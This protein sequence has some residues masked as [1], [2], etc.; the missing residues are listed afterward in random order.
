MAIS[1]TFQ[2]ELHALPKNQY[3]GPSEHQSWAPGPRLKRAALLK[4]VGVSVHLAVSLLD[5]AR[6]ALI[7][8]LLLREKGNTDDIYIRPKAPCIDD[9]YSNQS[10]GCWY[11][12]VRQRREDIHDNLRSDRRGLTFPTP[13][14]CQHWREA[15]HCANSLAEVVSVSDLAVFR[16]LRDSVGM[17]NFHLCWMTQELTPDLHYRRLEIHG[18][19]LLVLEAR[20]LNSCWMLATR[21]ASWFVS[22]YRHSQNGVWCEMGPQRG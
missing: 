8:R 12:F 2:T 5:V 10:V 7:I 20:A 9:I 19:I 21:N 15:V 16:H 17:K 22:E 18:R 14:S 13:E 3:G 4:N 11:P 6:A 1:T